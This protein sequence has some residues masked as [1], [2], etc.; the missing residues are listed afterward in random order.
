MT[1]W[2]A[3]QLVAVWERG[4]PLHPLDRTLAAVAEASS[5]C[6]AEAL[7]DLP[8][9]ELRR[10]ALSLGQALF[11]ECFA[12]EATCDACGERHEVSPP[13]HAVLAAPRARATAEVVHDGYRVRLRAVTTRDLAA[14]SH[15]AL[16]VHALLARCVLEATRDGSEV[17]VDALPAA[18]VDR[19]AEAAAE[20][21]P[22]AD[23]MLDLTC[24]RCGARLALL[25]DPGAFLWCELSTRARRALYEVH[26]LASHYGW[27]E[28]DILAMSAQRRAR[29]LAMVGA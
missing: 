18:L 8:V 4:A 24:V 15:G 20:L 21:D 1:S 12:G 5:A 2:T 29:Y 10:R 23:V 27:A 19:L 14:L 7:A 16:D 13:V 17:G 11:G 28:R 26:V 3:Q 22:N 6:D 9:G 25:F